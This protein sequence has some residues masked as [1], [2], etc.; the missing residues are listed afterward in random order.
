LHKV[1]KSWRKIATDYYNGEVGHGVL[2]RF[3]TEKDYLPKDEKILK[4]LELIKP[5]SPYGVLPKYFERSPK[6][7]AYHRRVRDIIR[8]AGA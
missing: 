3:A 4:S 2:Q 8:E 7:L 5:R 6:A 1:V